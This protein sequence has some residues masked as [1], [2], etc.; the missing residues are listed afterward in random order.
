V[1]P[2]KQQTGRFSDYD[3]T[4]DSKVKKCVMR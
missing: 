4:N 1:F 2:S 3:K